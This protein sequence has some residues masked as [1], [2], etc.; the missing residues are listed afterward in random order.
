[1]SRAWSSA[2]TPEVASVAVVAADGRLCCVPLL[3][4]TLGEATDAEV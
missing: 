1:M 3:L 4:A 2:Q